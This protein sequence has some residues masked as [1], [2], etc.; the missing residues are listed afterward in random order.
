MLQ[1]V[2]LLLGMSRSSGAEFLS[3]GLFAE[4]A[5]GMP[6][7]SLESDLHYFARFLVKHLLLR[8]TVEL[9]NLH[10]GCVVVH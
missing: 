1:P 9:H 6:S 4:L 8:N 7:G 5:G 3:V 2:D 10:W